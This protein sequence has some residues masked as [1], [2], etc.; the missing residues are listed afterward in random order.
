MRRV[1][2]GKKFAGCVKKILLY[3]SKQFII[4]KKKNGNKNED[5]YPEIVEIISSRHILLSIGIV[6]FQP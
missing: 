6:L 3:F 4:A 2:C 1:C 5:V